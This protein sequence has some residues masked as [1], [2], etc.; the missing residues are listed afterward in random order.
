MKAPAISFYFDDHHVSQPERV[1]QAMRQIAAAGFRTVVG[2]R[3]QCVYDLEDPRFIHSVEVGCAEARRLGLDLL[4]PIQPE[5]GLTG[6]VVRQHPELAQIQLVRGAARIAGGRFQIRFQQPFAIFGYWPSFIGVQAA[7]LREGG[8]VRRLDGLEYAADFFYD[9]YGDLHQREVEFMPHRPVNGRVLWELEG[10][11]DLQG[12]LIVYAGFRVWQHAD[13]ACPEY[14][15]ELARVLDLYRHLPAGGIVWDEPLGQSGEWG[16]S[17]KAGPGFARLFQQRHG[18]DLLDRIYLLDEEGD[19]AATAQVRHDYYATMTEALR[20]LQQRFNERARACFGPQIGLG[21]HHTWTGEGTSWDFRAGCFDYFTLTQHM[22]AGFVDGYWW[23]PRMVAY[24]LNLASSLGKAYHQGLAFSNCYNWGTTR[25]EQD[26]QTRLMALHRVDWF[27]MNYG[28]QCEQPNCYPLGRQWQGQVDG[29]SRLAQVSAFLAGAQNRPDT[30]IWHGWEGIARLN[31]S[32]LALYWK[33][34]AINTSHLFQERNLPFDFTSSELLQEG[35][36]RDGRWFTRA[37]VYRTVAFSYATMLPAALWQ[38]ARAFV[39]AGGRLIFVGPPPACTPAGGDLVH[40]FAALAGINP[41]PTDA[42][43]A[44]LHARLGPPGGAQSAAE[45]IVYARPTRID[46]SCPL[47]LPAAEALVDTEGETYGAKARGR[48]VYYLSGL[49]PQELLAALMQ[50]A[51]VAAAFAIELAEAYWRVYEGGARQYLLVM[52][53]SR[54]EMRGFVQLGAD[55]Y[56]LRGTGMV[57][58]AFEQEVLVAALGEGLQTL[59]RNGG[60]VTYQQLR[61]GPAVQRKQWRLPA[62]PLSTSLIPDE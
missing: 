51:P 34:F 23:D 15:E 19:P 3:R 58:L 43:L 18:Y 38:M 13:A 2:F 32:S 9:A 53:K 5:L 7:F 37:G 47:G 21:T 54:Q 28:D 59:S 4:L 36:V 27:A 48:E 17:Y 11:T 46:F 50:P 60:P 56:Y 12:E 41:L 30:A 33:A 25:R 57:L 61:S 40:E 45:L 29:A 31:D 55:R 8:A 62:A 49:D 20:G 44:A 52:A 35:Q 10:H 14:D 16:A 42:Y 22:S 1:V 39:A 6:R 24:T 26:F